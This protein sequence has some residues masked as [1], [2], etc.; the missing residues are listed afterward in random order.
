VVL[1]VRLEHHNRA[2]GLCGFC[3]STHDLLPLGNDPRRLYSIAT[4]EQSSM[5]LSSPIGFTSPLT[6]CLQA[7]SHPLVTGHITIGRRAPLMGFLSPSAHGVDE[8]TIAGLPSPTSVPLMSFGCDFSGFL[9]VDRS[10][11]FH[12]ETLMGFLSR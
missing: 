11:I 5:V 9:L 10:E 3:L 7:S 12:P 2:G 8:S 1:D 4:I 6:T